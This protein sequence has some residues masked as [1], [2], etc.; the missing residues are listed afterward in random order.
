[1][2]GGA[3]A[4]VVGWLLLGLAAMLLLPAAVAAALSEQ[5]ARDGFFVAAGVSAFTGGIFVT[6]FAGRPFVADRKHALTML[7]CAWVGLPLFA[8]IPFLAASTLAPSAAL[9]ESI[10]A[11]TTTGATAF[12]RLADV[13]RSLILWR[14]LLQWSGGLLTLVSAIAILLPLYGGETVTLRGGDGPIGEAA[15]NRKRIADA[16]RII[17]PVYAGLTAICLILLLFA[18]IPAFDALCLALATISTGG[19]MP[20]DGTIA[21]YGS[22]SA[23]LVLTMF[24]FLGAVSIFWTH[25]LLAGRRS[26]LSMGREPLYVASAIALG[27]MLI[28]AMLWLQYP[29]TYAAWAQ[30]ISLGLAAAASLVTTTGFPISTEAFEPVPFVLLL[31]VCA[32]GAG[33]L[34]TAG[35]LKFSRL[36][37]M[38]LQSYNELYLLLFPHGV[39]PSVRGAGAFRQVTIATIWALFFLT[40]MFLAVVIMLL[41]AAGIPF[42]GALLAA[43]TALSN[44]GPFYE[45]G[46]VTHLGADVPPIWEMTS[47]AHALMAVA[48][49]VGRVEL[50]AVVS[51]AR[52][53]LQRD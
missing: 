43:I 40:I 5:S 8:A 6:A 28:G 25:G 9:F 52:L 37:M 31:I 38:L 48:M 53:L 21:L 3:V 20:R 10:S 1:M 26:S 17:L 22:V 4:Y 14:A 39:H 34:S 24:M 27:G 23:E 46:R 12:R 45:I 42:Q 47:A 15:G 7:I 16:L 30:N 32:I 11:F 2:N 18:Q 41:A 51:L 35:G 49:I 36:V 44:A 19:F 29:S 33:R 13:A 50:L